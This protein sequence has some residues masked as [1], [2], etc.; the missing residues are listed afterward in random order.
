MAVDLDQYQLKS[1][2]L[3]VFAPDPDDARYDQQ[4]DFLDHRRDLLDEWRIVTFGIFEDGPSFAE[5]RAV[6][7]EDSIRARE[8][9]GVE[10]GDFGLRLL[11][12]DGTEILRSSEPLPVEDLVE[13]VEEKAG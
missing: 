12:L 13:L 3:I 5:Q 4:P 10:D 6:S 9:F 1:R 2:V 11:D 8:S 7:R